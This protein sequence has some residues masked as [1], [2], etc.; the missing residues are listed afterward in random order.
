ML[1]VLK[2]PKGLLLP[3]FDT[4]EPTITYDKNNAWSLYYNEAFEL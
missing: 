4:R 1:H 3:L 2:T